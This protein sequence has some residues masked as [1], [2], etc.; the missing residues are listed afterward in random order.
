MS[1]PA[2]SREVGRGERLVAGVYRLRLPLPWPGVPHGNAY[3]IASGD[4]F[5]MVDTGVHEAGSLANLERAL[6]QVDL[7]LDQANLL[8]CT[9]AHVDHYGEAATITERAECELWM[10]PNHQHT[11]ET[12]ANPELTMERR[13]EVALQC[14]VP[15]APLRKWMEGRKD[16]GSGLA[17]IVLPDR[18]LRDGDEIETDL[19]IWQVVETPG[20]APSHLC[21]YQPDHKYLASGDHLLGRVSL[22]Y[23]YGFT[24]DPVGEFLASLDRVEQLEI[25]LVFAGHGKPFRDVQAHI[26]ANR[27]LVAERLEAISKVLAGPEPVLPFQIAPQV[28]GEA[29]TPGTAAWLF[30]KTLCYLTHLELLG[31]AKRVETDGQQQLWEAA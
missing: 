25:E 30:S 21:F 20:H 14:G 31:Q 9:H 4:G 12:A 15:E 6:D 26:D 23:D 7:R 16:Q 1:A 18:E 5:V 28:Y 29:F 11:T 24:P 19:G 10:S 27:K 17:G 2:H 22:Y 8:I 3:A 13:I